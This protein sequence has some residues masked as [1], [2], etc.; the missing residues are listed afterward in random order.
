MTVRVMNPMGEIINGLLDDDLRQL[1]ISNQVDSQTVIAV[2]TLRE[3]QDTL[4]ELCAVREH[5]LGTY[6]MRD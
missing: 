4:I 2:Q 5:G 3:L 6:T 1:W